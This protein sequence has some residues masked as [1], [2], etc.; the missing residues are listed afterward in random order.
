[1][2]QHNFTRCITGYDRQHRN[3]KMLKGKLNSKWTTIS[4]SN[5]MNFLNHKFFLR[6]ITYP[7]RYTCS[8]GKDIHYLIIF[9]SSVCVCVVE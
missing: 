6:K 9:I 3:Q 5:F 1:M 7:R 4:W 2:T 8:V